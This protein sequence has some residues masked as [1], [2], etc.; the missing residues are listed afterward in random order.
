M[1]N[2]DNLRKMN[3]SLE[4]IAFSKYPKL[5]ILKSYLISLSK[6]LFVRMTGSG[7]ALV[8]YYLSKERCEKAK[9]SLIGNLKIIGVYHQ[10]LYKFYFFVLYDHYIGA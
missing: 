1:F 8:A 6:P 7:S 4:E 2:F 10:K 5:R 3:N 9:N